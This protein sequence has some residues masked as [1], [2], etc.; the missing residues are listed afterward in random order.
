M[1]L[2][3]AFAGAGKARKIIFL[4]GFLIFVE[5]QRLPRALYFFSF[6][7]N[8]RRIYE[9][10]HISDEGGTRKTEDGVAENEKC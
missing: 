8:K 4:N 10:N 3:R 7:I 1:E 9:W 5:M 2:G 6:I